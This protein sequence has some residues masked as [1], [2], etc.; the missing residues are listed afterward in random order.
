MPASRAGGRLSLLLLLLCLAAGAALVFEYRRGPEPGLAAPS[1]ESPVEATSEGTSGARASSANLI[2]MPS[3]ASLSETVE[4]PLFLPSRR[5]VAAVENA[6]PAT[7][8]KDISGLA[9]VGVV[10]ASEER[11]AILKHPDQQRALRV[12]EGDMVDG[13]LVEQV[14]ATGVVLKNRDVLTTLELKDQ[15][16][17]VGRK[18][19]RGA[20]P[21]AETPQQ[22]NQGRDQPDES[23]DESSN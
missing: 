13:W 6:A 23:Q 19:K 12:V 14:L 20:A 1:E 17:S 4:R 15:P 18:P 3:L 11:M 21:T 10:M 16:R 22:E 8:A 2:E 9:V 7:V 5:P